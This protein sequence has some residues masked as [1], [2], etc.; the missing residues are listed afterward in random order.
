MRA[1]PLHERPLLDQA[2]DDLPHWERGAMKVYFGN[3][4]DPPL[5]CVTVRG[6]GSSVRPHGLRMR[7]D[8]RNHSPAGF[9]WGYSGAAPAALALA[10]LADATGDDAA[11]TQ[12]YQD[13]KWDVIS[14]LPMDRN[15]T[16]SAADVLGWVEQ[17]RAM[18]AQA[19]AP[20]RRGKGAAP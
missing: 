14:K 13:F 19:T 9:G 2:G 8:L 1:T 6:P 20:Q 17:Q 5:Y 12:L 4:D 18:Q 11:A 15:W 7:K 3:A 16:L 10:I